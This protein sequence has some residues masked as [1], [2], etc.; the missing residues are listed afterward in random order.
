MYGCGL[1]ISEATT[2]EVGAIDSA[3]MLL[4]IIGKGN[5]QRLVPPP[6]PVLDDLPVMWR[7]HRHP[8]WLF[9]RR[10]GTAPV[11]PAVLRWAFRD[12]RDAARIK[13]RVTAHSL[14]HPFAGKWCR[15][16]GRS[17]PAQN[18]DILPANMPLKSGST[19]RSTPGAARPFRSLVGLPIVALSWSSSHSPRIRL[20]AYRRG[21]CGNQQRN[22][23]CVRSRSSRSQSSDRC[24]PRLM[25]F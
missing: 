12:G 1:R 4:R 25:R 22:A 3:N 6:Q 5:K 7:T 20:P 24:V 19:I 18:N 2:L 15:H 17:D 16:Q 23:A 8:R 11:C 10:D 13:Q 14:R 9:P 21:W